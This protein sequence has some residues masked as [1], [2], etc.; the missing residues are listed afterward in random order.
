MH[1]AIRAGAKYCITDKKLSKSLSNQNILFVK[2]QK[3]LL[4][5]SK[6]KDLYIKVML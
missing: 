2:I 6:T 3:F 4:D 5:L 1:E